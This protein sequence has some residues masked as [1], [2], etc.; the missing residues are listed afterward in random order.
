MSARKAVPVD[1]TTVGV[2]YVVERFGPG[3]WRQIEDSPSYGSALEAQWAR[4][5]IHVTN[6][7]LALS[8]TRVTSWSW[9]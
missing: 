2:Y 8:A 3:G 4:A 9:S 6:K 5:E 1:P 7:A